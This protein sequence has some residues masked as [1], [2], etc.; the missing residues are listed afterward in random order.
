MDALQKE[1]RYTYADYAGWDTKER[2]ELIDGVPHL[3]SPAPTWKHQRISRELSY[4]FTAFLKGKPCEIFA[5]PFDVRL[6]ADSYDD[7]VIQ[8]DLV[9]ICDKSKLS[10]TGCVGAPDMVVE[11]L[12]PSTAGYDRVLKFN[13]YMRAGIREYWIIDPETKTVAVHVLQNGGYMTSAYAETDIVPVR[14]LEG[15]AINLADVFAE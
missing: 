8:P 2:Y 11:I 6:N 4:Q 14:V 9:V 12:S 7:T 5:A 1:T 15:C 3:M 10:G 13:L